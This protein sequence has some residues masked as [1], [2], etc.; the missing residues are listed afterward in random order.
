MAGKIRIV[1]F[2][3]VYSLHF[4]YLFQQLCAICFWQDRQYFGHIS[5]YGIDQN[6]FFGHL[7]PLK[8]FKCLI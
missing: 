5:S 7:N 4:G 1:N 6:D 8:Y 3:L 2:S